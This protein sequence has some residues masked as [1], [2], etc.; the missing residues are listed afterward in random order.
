[1]ITPAPR[2]PIPTTTWDAI[3]VISESGK[4]KEN[5][6]NRNDPIH[7]NITVLKPIARLLYCLSNPIQ[8]LNIKHIII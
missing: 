5:F 4:E 1:M 3:L 8:K 7:T 6:T 2:K